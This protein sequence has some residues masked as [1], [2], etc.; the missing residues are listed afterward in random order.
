MFPQKT[1]L[2]FLWLHSYSMVY[3][4]HIFFLRQ[5]LALSTRLEFSGTIMA[6]CSIDLLGLSNPSASV[7]RVAGTTGVYHHI[8]LMFKLFFCRYRVLLCWPGWFW[9]SVPKHFSCPSL[10]K[11]WGYRCEPPCIPK[12]FHII[13]EITAGLARWLTPV[14]PALWKAKADG[15]RGQEI[16]TIL[17]NMVKPRLY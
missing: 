11:C 10:P 15:S 14:I 17:V 3:M 13:K 7:S 16:K 6:H 8:Q 2:H 9:T 5:S 12:A 1:W 4:Y